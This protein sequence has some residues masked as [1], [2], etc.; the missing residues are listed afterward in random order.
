[1]P[2]PRG[3]LSQLLLSVAVALAMGCAASQV[4]D[5]DGDDNASAVSRVLTIDELQAI[6]LQAGT[7]HPIAVFD[8]PESFHTPG[9]LGSTIGP[10][11]G[12]GDTTF[13]FPGAGRMF[14]LAGNHTSAQLTFSVV[15]Q[16]V[17]NAEAVV[18]VRGVL[19]SKHVTTGLTLSEDYAQGRFSGP[20]AIVS[21]GM[22]LAEAGKDGYLQKSVRI[23]A[24][25]SAVMLTARH[26]V[27][28]EIFAILDFV[29]R[30]AASSAPSKFRFAAT[31][32]E[33]AHDT[34]SL[35][36][37]AAG[38]LV[39]AGT[40]EDF[41][42]ENLGIPP[43]GRKILGRANGVA[44]VGDRVRASRTV[45]LGASGHREGDLFLATRRE[46]AN[47]DTSEIVILD[48]V[49]DRGSRAVDGNFGVTYEL[50]YKVET[51]EPRTVD[52]LLTAPTD[53][54]GPH[55][56]LGG[57]LTLGIRWKSAS[58][59]S[60]KAVRV[61]ARGDAVPL[62]SFAVKPGAPVSFAIEFTHVGNTFPPAGIEFRT[63]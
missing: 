18:E 1:M 51:A 27:R 26:A 53:R 25:A 23:A 48:R 37:L 30:D 33:R 15:V 8:N 9:V 62:A 22:A 52:I 56:A 14:V 5:G 34:A 41:A 13:D 60:F 50:E 12:R 57:E 28:G 29:A 63:R 38:T 42:P 4:G 31:S 44:L 7:T 21:K 46:A 61:D 47:G 6:H 32:T 16:N 55:T 39:G 35:K 2:T 40:D 54:D 20:H 17:S 43:P 24:H 49:L 11:K 36:A 10:V 3:F 59:E 45:S 58:G 19:Y